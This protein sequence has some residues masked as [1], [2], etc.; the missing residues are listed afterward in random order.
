[1]KIKRL[2]NGAAAIAAAAALLCG[3]NRGGVTAGKK[4]NKDASVRLQMRISKTIDP[5]FVENGAVREVLSLCYEPLFAVDNDIKVFGVL[6]KNCIV[7]DDCKSAVITLK[8]GVLWHSG[9]KFTASDVVYTVEKI[10]ENPQSVYSDCVK[11]IETTVPID[12][13]TVRI[14][15]SRPYAQIAYSLWFPII[16]EGSENLDEK[17]N[18]TGAYRLSEYLPATQLKLAA[19]D[20]WHGGMA[21]CNEITVS[22]MRDGETAGAAFASGVI[23]AVTS[24]DYDLY[25]N[26]VK[27][28]MRTAQYAGTRLEY[29]AFNHTHALFKSA[30]VRQAAAC[31]INRE[32]ITKDCYKG[33][34]AAKT[35]LHPGFAAQSNGDAISQYSAENAQELMFYEGYTI[36]PETGKLQNENKNTAAFKILVNEEN[37][38]RL[39]CA[40]TLSLQLNEAG[41]STEVS[42]VSFEEYENAIKQGNFDAYVGGV[43][44]MNLFDWEFLL[45]KDG[46]LNSFGYAS[47][48]TELALS[49]LAKASTED[50]TKDAAANFEEVFMRE[51]PVCPLAFLEETLVTTDKIRGNL[52]P[53]INF[54]YQNLYKWNI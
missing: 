19:F 20:K 42:A 31:A 24:K 33:A 15:L 23:D 36:D 35:V 46:A 37:T 6:A 49:A 13:K 43:Q 11:Y 47:D 29:L 22:L 1:M 27:K 17:I 45:S 5:I 34:A 3:C 51:Q 10:K 12:E 39:K 25:E 32:A 18:G 53:I 40:Q 30:N 44:P 9:E 4:E 14:E 50:A 16:R 28:N 54:P 26:A 52:S 38:A 7:S 2:I 41:F 8:D 48:Y 21:K